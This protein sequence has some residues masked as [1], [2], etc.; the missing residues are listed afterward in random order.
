M[1]ILDVLRRENR[2]DAHVESCSLATCPIQSSFYNYRPSLAA[3][4]TFLALFS[5]SLCCFVLQV[6]LSRRFVGFSIALIS[7]CILEVLGYV[8]RIMSYH[9][10]FFKV[11]QPQP[12]FTPN[13]R[14]V[15]MLYNSFL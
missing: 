6:A 5:F 15:F 11:W 4:A 2:H 3:N 10:P 1:D 7:G 13:T 14:R 9:N 8:G 12:T